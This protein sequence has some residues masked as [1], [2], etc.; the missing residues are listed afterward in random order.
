MRDWCNAVEKEALYQGYSEGKALP[1]LKVVMSGGKRRIKDDHAAIER[2]VA[3][4]YDR[5]LVSRETAQ[6]LGNLEKVVGKERLP[7]VLGSLLVKGE[8]SPSLVDESDERP[9]ISPTTEAQR[10]FRGE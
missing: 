7:L 3:E 5:A 1:G 4:G 9:A 8:G 6:T 2:L 10:D